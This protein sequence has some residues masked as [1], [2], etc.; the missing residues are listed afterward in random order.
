MC[1][2]IKAAVARAEME[3]NSARQSAAQRKRALHGRAP[4]GKRPLCYAVDS[5]VI[6]AS[7]EAVRATHALFTKAEHP[8]SLRSLAR[9]GRSAGQGRSKASRPCRSTHTVSIEHP[10]ARERQGLGP[11]RI[12]EDFSWSPAT[13]LDILR[14]PR[15]STLSTYTPKIAQT[16]GKRRRTWKAQILRD[17][18]ESRSGM[19]GSRSSRTRSGRRLSGCLTTRSG[20]RTLP[21]RPRE[22]TSVGTAARI[23]EI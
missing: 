14:S 19:Y 12:V 8:E 23:G 18:P 2:R 11:R 17:E 10:A 3:R 13:V 4:K 20:S 9:A 22:S 16:D 6:P 5:E 15:S 1:A 7:A 21:V